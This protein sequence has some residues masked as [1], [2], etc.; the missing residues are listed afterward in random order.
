[1][2]LVPAML[3]TIGTWEMAD[4]GV[5]AGLI[6]LA[7]AML[8]F[9]LIGVGLAV[10]TNV[11]RLF[12]H[13]A[14]RAAAPLPWPV[15]ALLAFGVHAVT[16]AVLGGDGSP[17][18]ASLIL[19]LGGALAYRAWGQALGTVVVPG[20]LQLAPGFIGTKAVLRL[21][22]GAQSGELATFFQ[23]VT[24]SLELTIGLMLALVIVRPRGARL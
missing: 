10:A 18:L 21:L 22:R 9:L 23:V 1:A 13:I 8:R 11:A 24:T 17:L 12:P 5:E 4:G 2:L 20:L 6:R 3:L 14:A 16:K 19:G 7:Y 15:V